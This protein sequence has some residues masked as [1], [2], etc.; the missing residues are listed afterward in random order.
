MYIYTARC[1]I[2]RLCTSVRLHFGT[3]IT[4]P[5]IPGD[6]SGIKGII[7]SKKYSAFISA[8]ISVHLSVQWKCPERRVRPAANHLTGRRCLSDSSTDR[9][10]SQFSAQSWRSLKMPLGLQKGSGLSVI[11]WSARPRTC[12]SWLWCVSP[13]GYVQCRK[14]GTN[15]VKRA[16]RPSKSAFRH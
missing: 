3:L 14:S 13:R 12:L 10:C 6:S 11:Y 5:A 15:S 9:C 4:T 2:P 8:I 1:I 7:L 16:C